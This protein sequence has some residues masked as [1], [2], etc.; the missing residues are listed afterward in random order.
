MA[1]EGRRYRNRYDLA[2]EIIETAERPARPL[3]I[4]LQTHLNLPIVNRYLCLLVEMGLIRRVGESLY[5]ATFNGLDYLER[6]WRLRRLLEVEAEDS[7]VS[8]DEESP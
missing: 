3:E 5:E 8:E 2:A 7:I 4:A 6:Y 1:E